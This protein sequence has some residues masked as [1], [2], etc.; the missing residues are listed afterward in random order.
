M[1]LK[2][3]PLVQ[4]ALAFSNNR[5]PTLEEISSP[6][7]T[8]HRIALHIEE[9]LVGYVYGYVFQEP[10]LGLL[11]FSLLKH[12]KIY[13]RLMILGFEIRMAMLKF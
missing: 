3:I 1:R 13:I 8:E 7:L 11:E 5:V 9:P 4:L 12:V 10:L 2:K 6:I